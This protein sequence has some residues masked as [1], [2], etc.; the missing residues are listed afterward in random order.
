MIAPGYTPEALAILSK[1]K[2]GNFVILEGDIDYVSP[3]IETICLGTAFGTAAM[4][5][6]NGQQ[7]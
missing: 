2:G 5:L 7:G 1:K 3:D 4:L 6:A